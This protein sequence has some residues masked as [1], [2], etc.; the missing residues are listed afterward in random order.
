MVTMTVIGDKEV[1]RNLNLLERRQMGLAK[2][3]LMAGGFVISNAAKQIIKE[4]G[5]F[6]TRDMSRSIHPEVERGDKSVKI[7]S[8][9]TNPPYP[10]YVEFGTGPHV[11][12]TRNGVTSF[13]HPGMPP[14]P[15]LRPALD[16]NKTEAIAAIAATLRILV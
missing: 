12:K 10:L 5:L 3:G 15:F 4:K 11:Q 13:M 2:A 14:R 6:V 7:G 1:R 9:I 16:E 8:D